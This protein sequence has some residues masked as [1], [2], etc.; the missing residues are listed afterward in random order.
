[1][2][3]LPY[4]GEMDLYNQF[5]LDEPWDSEHNKPLVAR[6]PAVYRSPNSAVWAEGRTNYLTPRNDRSIFPGSKGITFQEITDG[7]SNTIMLLEV[8]DEKAVIWTKPDDFEYDE[9]APLA[10]LLGPRPG[11]NVGFADGSVRFFTASI[12]P[13]ALNAMFTRNGGESITF[14]SGAIGRFFQSALPGKGAASPAANGGAGQHGEAG[15]PAQSQL[16]QQEPLDNERR[17]QRSA[18]IGVDA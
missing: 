10:G 16:S 18:S 7:L 13:R 12:D 8:A 3:I 15:H 4:L 11:F 17:W 1:M 14:D 9:E 2:L 6:M 5:H